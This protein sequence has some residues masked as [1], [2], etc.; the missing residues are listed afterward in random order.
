MKNTDQPRLKT[1]VR[2][3]PCNRLDEN[4][5]LGRLI[6]SGRSTGASSATTI[7]LFVVAV[8]AR[9][10]QRR[11]YVPLNC[12]ACDSCLDSWFGN[13]HLWKESSLFFFRLPPFKVVD[14]KHR[15]CFPRRSPCPPSWPA[16]WRVRHSSTAS[17]VCSVDLLLRIGSSS[18]Q[19]EAVM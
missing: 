3:P 10:R 6:S 14:R 2:C 7:G 12:D 11:N 9:V 8:V 4:S 18:R 13:W 5:R 16:S 1:S 15:H 17:G 19:A